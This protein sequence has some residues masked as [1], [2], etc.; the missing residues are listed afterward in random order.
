MQAREG[1]RAP[2]VAGRETVPAT[3]DRANTQDEKIVRETRSS[4]DS[5]VYCKGCGG[6]VESRSKLQ[7]PCVVVEYMMC[8]SCR[9]RHGHA[10]IP[11]PGAP[12]YCFRCG[13]K[14]EIFIEPSVSPITHHVCVRC[15]PEQAQRYRSGDFAPPPKDPVDVESQA[16]TAAR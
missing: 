14:E 16:K 1:Q 10:L 5:F 8:E 4:D 12:T 11:S 15:L 6:Q 2:R 13:R 9:E 3:K 7:R